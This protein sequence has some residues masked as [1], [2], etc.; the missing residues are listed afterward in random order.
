M[1]AR[2]HLLA[3]LALGASGLAFAQATPPTSSPD[4]AT[5]AAGQQSRAAGPMGTTGTSVAQ[6]QSTTPGTSPSS[7]SSQSQ[8]PSAM[9]APSTDT[10]QAQAPAPSSEPMRPQRADRN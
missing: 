10:T 6:A 3:V 4:P 2:K 7:G 9:P 5:T 8:T 1:N